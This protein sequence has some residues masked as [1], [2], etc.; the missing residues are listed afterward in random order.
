MNC[1]NFFLFIFK[2]VVDQLTG[3]PLVIIN[4]IS[5]FN[6]PRVT[7]ENNSEPFPRNDSP[8]TALNGTNHDR[9]KTATEN[10]RRYW[11]KI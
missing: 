9:Q 10:Q 4:Y 5:V 8:C 3:D 6:A 7:N 11:V 1:N 2:M